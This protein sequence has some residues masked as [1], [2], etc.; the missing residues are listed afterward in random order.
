MT[1]ARVLET[2]RTLVAETESALP[3]TEEEPDIGESATVAALRKRTW[4]AGAKL[5]EALGTGWRSVLSDF[6]EGQKI[7]SLE[8]L[9][10]QRLAEVVHEGKVSFMN[11]LSERWSAERLLHMKINCKLSR[12]N[13]TRSRQFYFKELDKKTGKWVRALVVCVCVCVRGVFVK[14]THTY[15]HIHITYTHTHIH[16]HKISRI[17]S[18]LTA[19]WSSHLLVRRLCEGFPRRSQQSM[20]CGW[21]AMAR[22]Q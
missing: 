14:Q 3:P 12:R 17:R 9:M 13:Y 11:K 6:L 18:G 2:C 15:T 7:S 16:T 19:C 22:W 21:S 20:V 8:E 10:P 4:R 5:F 1:K